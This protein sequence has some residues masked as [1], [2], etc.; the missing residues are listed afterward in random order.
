M[1]YGI[2][3]GP[4]V[5]GLLRRGYAVKVVEDANRNFNGTPFKKSD[6]I[7]QKQNPYP[8]QIQGQLIDETPL[9]FITTKEVLSL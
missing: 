2:E 5:L 9:Q 6:V 4:V 1:V 8:D 3:V 7:D